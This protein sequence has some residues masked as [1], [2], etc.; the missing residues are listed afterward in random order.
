MFGSQSTCRCFNEP[1]C[2]RT[3]Q[4]NFDDSTRVSG[5]SAHTVCIHR[6]R[7]DAY[8]HPYAFGDSYSDNGA[9]DMLTARLVAQ[10]VKD[11]QVLPGPLYGRGAGAMARPPSKAWPRR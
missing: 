9:G 11:A 2:V 5:C 10:Q 8:D 4:E 3:F 7:C 6:V 1:L